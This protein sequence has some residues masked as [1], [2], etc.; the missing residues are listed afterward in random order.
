VSPAVSQGVFLM[1]RPLS[2]GQHTVH[3]S[4]DFGPGNFALDVTYHITVTPG[5]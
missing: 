5:H 2:V 3:F 4:G 1:L